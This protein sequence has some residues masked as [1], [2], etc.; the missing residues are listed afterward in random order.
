[1]WLYQTGNWDNKPIVIFDYKSSRSGAHPQDYLNGFHGFLHTDGY[2]GYE[3]VDGIVRCGCWAHL[4][5]KFVEAMPPGAEKLI[6]PCTAEIGKGYCDQL[7]KL[8][9]EFAEFSYEERRNKRLEK[10]KPILEAFWCWLETIT[11]LKNSKLNKAITYAWN[12]KKYL[13]N[14][15]LDGR[16]SLSNNIAENSIR[17]FCV[18]RKNWLFSES[19]QGAEA[20]AAIYSIIETAKANEINPMLYLQYIFTYMPEADIKNNPDIMESMMPWSKDYQEFIK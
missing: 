20:S 3:K 18:G 13:E 5:R 10:E 7:F 17:P 19:T 2:G 15:L 12:Q 14:Y 6:T 11:A 1:M 8:E 16:C 4:R 9:K